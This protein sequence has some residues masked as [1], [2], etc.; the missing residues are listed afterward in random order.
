MK[1]SAILIGIILIC[2]SCN[3]GDKKTSDSVSKNNTDQ[4]SSKAGQKSYDCL[5]NYQEDYSKLLTKEEMAAAYPIDFEKAKHELRSGSYGEYVYRWPSDRPSFTI[6]VSGMKIQNP[7]Q[8]TIGIKMLS[9]FSDKTDAQSAA[10]TFDMAYKQLSDE[11][12]D[13]I[14]ANL[15]KQN[16]EIKKTGEDM[17]KVR[18]KRSWEFVEGLGSR[19]WYKW[20]D[21]YGGELA[22]LA[23]KSKFYIINKISNDPRENLEVAKKLAEKVIVKCD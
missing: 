12:L 13:K 5:K 7:D 19:A 20:D 2:Y 16:D 4:V 11:E 3:S 6:E 18:A 23:G 8:N 10:E 1:N 14:K 21:Q 22:V 17:M 15:D 9:F